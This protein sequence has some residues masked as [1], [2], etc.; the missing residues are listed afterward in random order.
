LQRLQEQLASLRS[1]KESLEG[2]LFDAQT[3]LEATDNKRAQL[4]K[5]KQELLVRQES[6]KGQVSNRNRIKT[7]LKK[8]EGSLEWN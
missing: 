8:K 7:F 6:L 3:G 4:E 5:D 1:E 2:I